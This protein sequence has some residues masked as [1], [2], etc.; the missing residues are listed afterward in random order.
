MKLDLSKK[1]P[2]EK[3]GFFCFVLQASSKKKRLSE[4]SLFL[5]YVNVFRIT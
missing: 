2:A 1:P 3:R 5:V 4:Q